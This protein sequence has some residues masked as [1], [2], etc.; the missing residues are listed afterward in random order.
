MT[1]NTHNPR[2]AE[3]RYQLIRR[4]Q[5]QKQLERIEA[6]VNQAIQQARSD[7]EI[8]AGYAAFDLYVN[9]GEVNA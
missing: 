4:Y 5:A 6:A 7:E 1:T 9:A 3:I 8:Q 2:V